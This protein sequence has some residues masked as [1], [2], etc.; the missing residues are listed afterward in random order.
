MQVWGDVQGLRPFPLLNQ[1]LPF[2]SDENPDF[3]CWFSFLGKF[4]SWPWDLSLCL[5]HELFQV[6]LFHWGFCFFNFLKV[7]FLVT[8]R[9]DFKRKNIT[10]LALFHKFLAIL[11]WDFVH[12]SC[13]DFNGKHFTSSLFSLKFGYL[14]FLLFWHS[15]VEFFT[16]FSSRDN[17]SC[18]HISL[19]A[20]WWGDP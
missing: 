19:C 16:I 20:W 14:V 1:G 17:T 9:F 6:F 4:Q 11:T 8:Q 12:I 10:P 2:S 13:Q 5:L 3:Y 15:Y 18:I 7:S